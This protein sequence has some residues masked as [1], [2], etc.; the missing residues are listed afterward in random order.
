[1]KKNNLAEIKK[2]EVPAIRERVKKIQREVAVLVMDKNTNKLTNLKIIKNKRRDL[3]QMMTVIRQKNL[4]AQMEAK[5]SLKEG[6]E[7]P[8]DAK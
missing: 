2:M 6:Q 5:S 8:K 1:M 7:K 4:L 3:A